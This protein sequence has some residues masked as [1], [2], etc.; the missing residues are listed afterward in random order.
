M[1]TEKPTSKEIRDRICDE[2]YR[3]IA[4]LGFS[5]PKGGKLHYL[6]ST[7]KHWK[8]Y[9][10][11]HVAQRWS[12]YNVMPMFIVNWSR[13][14]EIKKEMEPERKHGPLV[15]CETFFN[16]MT[17]HITSSDQDA[18]ENREK[19]QELYV[20]ETGDIQPAVIRILDVFSRYG[21]PWLKEWSNKED[22][23]QYVLKHGVLT[24]WG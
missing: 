15:V 10:E 11:V 21:I 3:E 6:K 4:L 22:A 20:P 9:L 19:S 1:T 7:D 14:R 13:I 18:W 8:I 24:A 23:R 17:A 2:L 12:E 5:E 16:L